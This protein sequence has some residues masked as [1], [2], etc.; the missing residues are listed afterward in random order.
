M[1]VD[2]LTIIGIGCFTKNAQQLTCAFFIASWHLSSYNSISFFWVYP[3]LKWVPFKFFAS[4]LLLR[5]RSWLPS[6][7][8]PLWTKSNARWGG[9]LCHWSSTFE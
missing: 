1:C 5:V 3:K 6:R 8:G 7:L 4:C 9:Y 2:E